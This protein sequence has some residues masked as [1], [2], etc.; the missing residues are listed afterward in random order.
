M[1]LVDYLGYG[2]EMR[3]VFPW[4]KAWSYTGDLENG[5]NS[6]SK[7]L[8]E[9]W[10]LERHANPLVDLVYTEW[11][12]AGGDRP[13][14][15]PLEGLLCRLGSMILDKLVRY[16]AFMSLCDERPVEYY[17]NGVPV[18]DYSWVDER[19]LDMVEC[20]V[21]GMTGVVVY[22][23][24]S[25]TGFRPQLLEEKCHV[26]FANDKEWFSD[27]LAGSLITRRA[28]PKLIQEVVATITA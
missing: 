22:P 16:R 26:D 23:C 27:V 13:V 6:V 11:S 2:Y 4:W 24:G 18:L 5:G 14:G 7:T 3:A 28:N 10:M 17:W 21:R 15:Y 20:A 25:G 19:D 1:T 9:K 12:E 8:E